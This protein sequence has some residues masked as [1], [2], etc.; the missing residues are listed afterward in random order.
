M[1]TTFDELGAELERDHP[2]EMEE[3]KR[4]VQDMLSTEEGRASLLGLFVPVEQLG[5][6]KS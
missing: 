1:S 5:I 4:W 2:E 3:A 6:V